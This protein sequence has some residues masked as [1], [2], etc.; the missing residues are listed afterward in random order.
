MKTKMMLCLLPVLFL[1]CKVPVVQ[2][3]KIVE[4]PVAVPCQP[5]VIPPKPVLPASL[6]LPV[7][8]DGTRDKMIVATIDTLLKWI[9]ILENRI[10]QH[11]ETAAKPEVKK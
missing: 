10:H 11:N 7:T 8:E 4:V 9:E 1:A 5:I 3:P 6:I 2:P